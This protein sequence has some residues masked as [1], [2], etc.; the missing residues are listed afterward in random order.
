MTIRDK[1][2][3]EKEA[4]LASEETSATELWKNRTI[5]GAS[6]RKRTKWGRKPTKSTP[7]EE[8][9]L[10]NLVNVDS[11]TFREKKRRNESLDVAW[12]KARQKENSEFRVFRL[13]F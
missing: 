6:R 10:L 1:A 4:I 8:N 3:Q 2:R 5:P 7:S 11:E 12:K 13:L 9:E